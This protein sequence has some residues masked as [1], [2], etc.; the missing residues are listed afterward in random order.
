MRTV[1]IFL[2]L[3]LAIVDVCALPDSPTQLRLGENFNQALLLRML[4]TILTAHG[5]RL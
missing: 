3:E 5:A 4:V 2:L 1:V